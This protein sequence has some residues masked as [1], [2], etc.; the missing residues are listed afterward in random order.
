M[1]FMYLELVCPLTDGCPEQR[2]EVLCGF[3]GWW[4]QS[5]QLGKVYATFPLTEQMKL[6]KKLSFLRGVSQCSAEKIKYFCN[7]AS[8]LLK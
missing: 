3:C 1:F 6:L 8:F 4:S 2:G 5:E 7:Q